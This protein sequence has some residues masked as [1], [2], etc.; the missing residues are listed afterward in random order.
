MGMLGASPQSR[1]LAANSAMQ[2]MKNR[3]RPSALEIQP[4][5]GRTMA[6]DNR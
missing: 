3:L 1:E 6:L 5:M 4:V 2:I